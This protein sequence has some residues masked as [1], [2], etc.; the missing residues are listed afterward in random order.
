[1]F[2]QFWLSELVWPRWHLAL[3]YQLF[4][5]PAIKMSGDQDDFRGG[6]FD[7]WSSLYETL[8]RL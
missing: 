1:M 5:S 6:E 3:I 8:L 2:M 4:K 7:H